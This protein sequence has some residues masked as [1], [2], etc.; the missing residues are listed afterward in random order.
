MLLVVS[1]Q[2][3]VAPLPQ[4]VAPPVQASA[5]P[6]LQTPPAQVLAVLASQAPQAAPQREVSVEGVV[7]T[8]AA[9]TPPV[10]VLFPK[11]QAIPP[12]SAPAQST[13]VPSAQAPTDS[14]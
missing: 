6:H 5:A 3:A 12:A 8:Q 1:K 9:G 4:Q 10:Q 2:P 14:A 13:C 7:A 11:P